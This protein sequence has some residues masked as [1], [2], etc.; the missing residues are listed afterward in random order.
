MKLSTRLTLAT[1]SLVLITGG[2]TVT[3][4]WLSLRSIAV[5]RAVERLEVNAKSLAADIQR[6]ARITRADTLSFAAAAALDGIIRAHRNGGIHPEDGTSE[7]VWRARMAARFAAE[8]AFKPAYYQFRIIGVEDGGRE[9]VRVDRS[10]EN[11][12]VRIVPDAELQRKGDTDYF[13]QASRLPAGA[14]LISPLELNREHGE[15]ETPNVPVLRVATP[16]MAPDG[17]VFGIVVV[18]VDMRPAFERIRAQ[19]TRQHRHLPHQ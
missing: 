3:A 9:I 5:P 11:G 19:Q 12:A 2:A 4:A 18:N 1:V 16:I 14:A 8:L 6:T 15:I 7:A 17:S 10:G 13:R